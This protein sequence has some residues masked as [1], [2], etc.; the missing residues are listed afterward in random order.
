[1]K[2]VLRSLLLASCLL[3]AAIQAGGLTLGGGLN[4]SS[5]DGDAQG[6]EYSHRIGFNIGIGYEA[7]MTPRFSYLPE[8]NLETRGDVGEA[9]DPLFGA[10][11]GR[12]ELLYLQIPVFMMYSAPVRKATLNLFAGPSLGVLLSGRMKF[13][14][15]GATETLDIKDD[16]EALDFGVEGGAGVEVPGGPG[17]FFFRP[18]YYLGLMP[19]EDAQGYEKFSNRNIKLKAGYTLNL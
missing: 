7:E 19:H 13:E 5:T 16:M 6:V 9:N 2:K 11:K 8:I 17:A 1:M 4:A 12:M 10:I 14:R 15:N 18:S 3:P